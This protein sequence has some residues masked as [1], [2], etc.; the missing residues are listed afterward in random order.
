MKDRSLAGTN[1]NRLFY[2][3]I[4]KDIQNNK[5]MK[6]LDY[7]KFAKLNRNGKLLN[8]KKYDQFFEEIATE[9]DKKKQ[10]KNK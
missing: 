10:L 6:P 7:D 9:K 5:R 1:N 4:I 8:I 3:P 2:E